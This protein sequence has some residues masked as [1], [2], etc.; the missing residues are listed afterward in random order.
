MLERPSRGLRKSSIT[1]GQILDT[2]N[3][4]IHR[5][6]LSSESLLAKMFCRTALIKLIDHCNSP[7][8]EIVSCSASL[9]SGMAA[10]ATQQL[11]IENL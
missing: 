11:D 9:G 5:E 4:F 2:S 1:G 6:L 7:A 3:V 10:S 8:I